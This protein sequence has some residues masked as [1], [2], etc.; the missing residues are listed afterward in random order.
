MNGLVD[1]LLIRFDTGLQSVLYNESKS[2]RSVLG[3]ANGRQ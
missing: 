3:F 2:A 1:I